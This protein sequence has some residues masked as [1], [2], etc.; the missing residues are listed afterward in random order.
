MYIFLFLYYFSASLSHYWAKII[1]N[2]LIML[3][4]EYDTHRTTVFKN[5]GRKI[6]KKYV[7][8]LLSACRTI[9]IR[10]LFMIENTSSC[11]HYL[12]PFWVVFKFHFRMYGEGSIGCFWRKKEAVNR[13]C[14]ATVSRFPTKSFACW[15]LPA[16]RMFLFYNEL[17][18]VEDEI[19]ICSFTY[20]FHWIGYIM[21][22]RWIHEA[23]RFPSMLCTTF[24]ICEW[25]Q[26]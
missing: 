25:N 16:L 5:G 7:Y 6:Y 26:E 14:I 3:H 12:P 11:V 4:V 20:A 19:W 1:D 24:T 9:N 21:W 22:S 8:Y 2:G 23:Y 10:G 17:R 15:L 13:L 18:L